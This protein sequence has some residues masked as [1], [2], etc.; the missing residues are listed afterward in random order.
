M[1]IWSRLG[2]SV[3]MAAIFCIAAAELLQT[4]KY[5]EDYKIYICSAFLLSGA[6]LGLS[7]WVANSRRAAARPKAKL[8]APEREISDQEPSVEGPIPTS[9]AYW[10][11]MVGI[12]GAILF[13]MQPRYVAALPVAARTPAPPKPAPVPQPATNYQAKASLV[14]IAPLK[15]Q[16]VTYQPSNPSALIDG[17]T[18]FVG[19][20]VGRAKVIAIDQ[21][22]VVV[23]QQGQTKVLRLSP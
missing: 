6:V 22:Q 20:S 3:A 10:G 12:F 23:E 14:P 9:L 8:L 1:N 15:L 16:G 19:D 11:V 13:F 18:Y 21:E 4:R 17:R 7:G 2:F 5:F